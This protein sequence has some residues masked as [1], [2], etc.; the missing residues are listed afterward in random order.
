MQPSSVA[1]LRAE[2][3]RMRELLEREKEERRIQ[4]EE[5]RVQQEQLIESQQ[6]LESSR[7]RYVDLYDFAPIAYVTMDANGLV[8]EINLTGA[9][10]LGLERARLVGTPFILHVAAED[11]RGFL[12]HLA[13]ARREL[14]PGAQTAVELTLAPRGGPRVPAELWIRRA[15]DASRPVFRTAL[16]DLTERRR[17]EAERTRALEERSRAEEERRATRIAGEAKDR[18][19]ATLSHELRAPL[20]AIGFALASTRQLGGLPDR[21][22]S[23]LDMMRRNLDLEARLIDDLLDVTRIQR[24]KLRI[25]PEVLDPYAVLEEVAR[26]CTPAAEASQVVLW[27]EPPDG[28]PCVKADPVRL[29]QAVWNLVTN[30]L[31]HTPVHGR[32]TLGVHP[33]AG[34]ALIEVR[35][36]GAGIRSEVL[37]RIFEA[38]EQGDAGAGAGPGLGLGLAIVKGIVESHGGRIDAESGGKDF[39]ARFT[40]VL[41]GVAR[42]RARAA[43]TT[44]QKPDVAAGP[45]LPPR[46]LPGCRV[47]FVED[48]EDSAT[49]ISE[50]L[51]ANGYEVLLASSVHDAIEHAAD[52]FDVVVSDLGLPDGTGHDVMT[53]L[54]STRSVPGIAL[55]GYGSDRDVDRAI[56]AGFDVHLTKPVDPDALLAAIERV[57]PRTVA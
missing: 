4:D 57:R 5:L 23:A 42:R 43:A 29:R 18:F 6:Q 49:A 32:I 35:D 11:R 20:T 9:R 15:A 16:V 13:H 14:T 31:R 38:F 3:T 2:L 8:E 51:R 34:D 45:R 24:G 17:A 40:I 27:L 19:L 44:A 30:A 33:V 47:L 56:A 46:P 48:N 28:A 1:A 12:S 25:V 36:T 54:R 22:A 26:M 21:A 50:F 10:L 37:P 52:T 55:S 53:R 7:D 39:G 41:P